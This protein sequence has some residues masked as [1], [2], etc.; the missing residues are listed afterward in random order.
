MSGFRSFHSTVTALLEATDNWA[1]DLDLG[2]VNAVVFLNL[3]RAFDTVN[4]SMLLSKLNSYE[5]KGNVYELLSSY[6]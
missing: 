3:Q 4:C 2:Y 6:Y 5:I 1:F